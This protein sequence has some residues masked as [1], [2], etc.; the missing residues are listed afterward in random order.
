[1]AVNPSTLGVCPQFENTSGTPSVGDKLFFYIAGTNT[2]QTTY[3]DSTGTVANTNPI[4]LNSLGQ[5]STEIWFTAGQT[6][7]A[8][9][10]PST[11]T[12]PPTSAIRSWDNLR[13]INDPITAATVTEWTLTSGIATYISAT[14]FSV[15]GNHTTDF[16]PVGRRLKTVNSGGTIYSTI[17]ASV[18]GAVT[19]VTLRND[20]GSLDAGLSAVSYGILSPLNPSIPVIQSVAFSA[21]SSV[22]TSMANNV[23]TKIAF[24]T[25]EYDLGGYFDNATNYRH[26]PLVPG[27]YL[28]TATIT[29]AGPSVSINANIYKN[30]A[31]YKAGG[32]G[33]NV[34]NSDQGNGVSATVSMNGTTDYVELFGFQNTGGAQNTSIVTYQTWFQGILIAK[35]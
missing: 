10:A 31:A 28:Y 5:P 12:D 19:T 2:K 23:Y 15:T 25:E 20:S 22:T 13:G 14:S 34:A 18:F 26:T 17:T 11:D 1:M 24:Q 33:G 35:T 27:I 29:A 32:I 3:T 16:F 4:V 9:W 30:G 8:V 21:T 6:Y 7:K